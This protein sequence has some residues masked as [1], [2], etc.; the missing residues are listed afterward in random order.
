[1][2]NKKSGMPRHVRLMPEWL[3]QS[4]LW[5]ADAQGAFDASDA[6]EIGLSDDLADRLEAWMDEFDSIFD[7]DNPAASC[8]ASATAFSAWKAEGEAIAKA[9]RTELGPD[10]RLD[11]NFPSDLVTQ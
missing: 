11:V 5:L 3:G 7:E 1:M 9:I 4:G 8:F 6:E 2:V 10:D